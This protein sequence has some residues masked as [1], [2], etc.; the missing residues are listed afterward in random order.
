MA[1]TERFQGYR[2]IPIG[3]AG[4]LAIGMA[5]LQPSI[6]AKPSEALNEYVAYW[7]SAAIF[8]IFTAGIGIWLRHRG[9]VNRLSREL[10]LLAVGQ[11]VPCI[12]A[13]G[14]ATIVIVRFAP[15]HS[16]LLP[17]L[18]Q[19][20]FSLGIFA[21]YR[22][23]PKSILLVGVWYFMFGIRNM[24]RSETSDSFSPW[25]MGL[26]FGLGQLGTAAILYWNLERN[27]HVHRA[28]TNRE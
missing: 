1:A 24:M 9:G 2:A 20:L 21:S 15:I 28:G 3:M 17:S 16:P 12:I 11:F 27:H 13:G 7:M 22:L 19:L 25:A 4:L 5:L 10:T 23:L 26:P 18:W 6:I 14:F 8:G